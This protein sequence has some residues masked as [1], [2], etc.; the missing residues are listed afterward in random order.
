M[1][2][3]E[4]FPPTTPN[5][6]RPLAF[7]FADALSPSTPIVSAVWTIS[8]AAESEGSDPE[9]ASRLTGPCVNMGL[10][11]TQSITG[12]LNGITYLVVCVVTANNGAEVEL[13]SYILCQAAE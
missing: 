8:T 7:N 2:V 6:I 10:V 12:C 11:S 5:E 13:S 1:Y 3:G 4:D 9:A